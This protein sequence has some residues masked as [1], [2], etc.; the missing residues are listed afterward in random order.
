MKELNPL[1]AFIQERIALWDKLKKEHDE[2]IA[3]Q[4]P[5]P[6]HV[7][8][9]LIY[10]KMMKSVYFTV[11]PTICINIDNSG[12]CSS[13]VYTGHNSTY[14]CFHLQ[15]TLPDGSV[16]TGESWRTTPYSVAAGIS[17]GLAESVIV[18]EVDGEV[19]DLD[20]P[21]TKDCKLKLLKFDDPAAKT[22]GGAHMF[23]RSINHSF[24]CAISFV[25]T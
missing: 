3:S 25:T 19:W 8:A 20:R 12:F 11:H 23:L 15:I 14:L 1:P 10:I 24:C 2:H 18:A 7:R 6:I 21:L 5:E 4:I 17:Q 9:I 13:S 16:R 22:V